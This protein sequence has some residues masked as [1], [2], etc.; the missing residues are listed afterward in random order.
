MQKKVYI[1]A[2]KVCKMF[3][4][5]IKS[6]QKSLLTANQCKPMQTLWKV[7][8]HLPP[9]ECLWGQA[10]AVAVWAW[11]APPG[12]PD[13]RRDHRKEGCCE[14]CTAQ[15]C[16]SDSTSSQGESSLI[17]STLCCM[18]VFTSMYENIQVSWCTSMYEYVRVCISIIRGCKYSW[19]AHIFLS[20]LALKYNVLCLGD[21]S[22]H[23]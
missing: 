8:I 15:A 13:H 19:S 14:Q 11:Q 18:I 9:N 3:P 7:Y 23:L 17:R 20:L 4:S 12:R 2:E 1:F 6:R 10:V 21:V 5:F 22:V 16:S